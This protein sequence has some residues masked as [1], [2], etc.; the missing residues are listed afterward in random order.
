MGFINNNR[1]QLNLLGYSLNDFVPM[2][3]K[4]RFVVDLVKQLDLSAL[5][6]RYSKQ[7]N[8]A[9]EPSTMLATWFYGYCERV[10]TTRKLEERCQR[11][12]YF[13]YVSS[14][15]RPDHSSLSRFRKN[16]QEL[17]SDYFV[18]IVRLAWEQGLSSFNEISIDGSKFQAASSARH[19][20]NA[21]EL[22]KALKRVRDDI[23][24]YMQRAELLDDEDNDVIDNLPNLSA[25][26]NELKKLEK[27]LK[28]KQDTLNKRR[29]QIKPEYRD[30]HKISLAEDDARVMD[31]VNGKQKLPAYNGQLSVDVDTQLIVANEAI[32]DTVDFDQFENQHQNV[33]N[34]LGADEQRAYNIDAGYHNFEQLDYIFSNNIDAIMASP[35]NPENFKDKTPKYFWPHQFIYD[36]ENDQYHCPAGEILTYETNYSKYPKWKG[37]VYSTNACDGCALKEKCLSPKTRFKNLRREERQHLAEKMLQQST[38][39]MGRARLKRRSTSVETAFG[40]IKHNLGFRRFNLKGLSAVKAEFNLV[41]IAHNINKLFKIGWPLSRQSMIYLKSI[42]QSCQRTIISIFKPNMALIYKNLFATPSTRGTSR[43]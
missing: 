3:A 42:W 5:Y 20:R 12:V 29:E 8:D 43:G 1:N 9:Y 4:C 40:N 14:N 26:I 18:Q 24:N 21:E 25:K 38:T 32:T 30:R 27:E 36:T 13:M 31:K 35:Q 39:P 33:E 10:F 23:A 7:G 15:L 2:N 19:L 11:D 16:N 17:M 37:R 41:C 28:G 34:T 22:E 6:A